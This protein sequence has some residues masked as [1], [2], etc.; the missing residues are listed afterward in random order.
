[1]TK[2]KIQYSLA[3]EAF[4]S[5]LRGFSLS[6]LIGILLW[7]AYTAFSEKVFQNIFFFMQNS[8]AWDPWLAEIA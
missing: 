1:M 6:V 5:F 2:T 4:K 7:L 8:S 3:S